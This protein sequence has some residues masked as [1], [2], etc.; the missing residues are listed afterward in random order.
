MKV[1]PALTAATCFCR[2]A[3]RWVSR[4]IASIRP[5]E[6]ITEVVTR[7]RE[8]AGGA[9][10]WGSGKGNRRGVEMTNEPTKIAEM[11]R[12]FD[13]FEATHGRPPRDSDELEAFLEGERK[14]G[15]V[16]H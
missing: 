16:G 13:T 6:M 11:L 14:A 12:T 8:L 15:R 1:K 7:A 2:E 4:S 3:Y 9:T 10:G 5:G